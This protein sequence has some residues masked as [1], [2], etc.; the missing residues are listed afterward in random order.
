[1]RHASLVPEARADRGNSRRNGFP[2]TLM[3]PSG[4]G[5]VWDSGMGGGMGAASYGGV[6]VARSGPEK[7]VL[8][9]PPTCYVARVW[10]EL[11]AT[12]GHLAHIDT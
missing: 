12:V 8:T 9:A 7:A 1:M 3:L 6:C 4:S 5:M 10:P 2:L 11:S